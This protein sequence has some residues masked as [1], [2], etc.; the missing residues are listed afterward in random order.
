MFIVDEKR[1]LTRLLSIMTYRLLELKNCSRINVF[2]HLL[3]FKMAAILYFGHI[4]ISEIKKCIIFDISFNGKNIVAVIYIT[5]RNFT[6]NIFTYYNFTF[7]FIQ[8][9]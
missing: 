7:L 8:T 2:T 4:G 3:P 1:K 5:N 6:N 9:Y